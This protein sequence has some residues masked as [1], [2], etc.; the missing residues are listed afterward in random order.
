MTP[1]IFVW[2]LRLRYLAWGV[3]SPGKHFVMLLAHAM[4]VLEKLN[5]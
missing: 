3:L 4:I 1:G 2:L 5:N